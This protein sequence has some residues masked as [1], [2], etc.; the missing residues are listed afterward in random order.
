MVNKKAL[1]VR[2][3]AVDRKKSAFGF[4]TEIN[5]SIIKK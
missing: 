2:F 4:F 3:V 1:F 5:Y